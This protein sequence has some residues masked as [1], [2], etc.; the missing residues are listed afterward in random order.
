MYDIPC[1]QVVDCLQN[2]PDSLGR[3]SFRE[4]ALVTDTIEQLST[5]G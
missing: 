1:M 3:I 2:L 4:F 5:H